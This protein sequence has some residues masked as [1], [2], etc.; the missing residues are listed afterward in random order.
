MWVLS[1]FPKTT[2]VSFTISKLPQSED[3]D[4][5]VCLARFTLFHFCLKSVLYFTCSRPLNDALAASETF[6]LISPTCIYL[7][8]FSPQ[9]SQLQIQK[10][11]KKVLTSLKIAC[12]GMYVLIML[13][14]IHLNTSASGHLWCQE[15]NSGSHLWSQE[16]LLNKRSLISLQPGRGHWVALWGYPEQMDHN[17][18]KLSHMMRRTDPSSSWS[19]SSDKPMDLKQGDKESILKPSTVVTDKPKQ[20][21]TPVPVINSTS[22]TTSY[23]SEFMKQWNILVVHQS[24]CWAGG[25]VTWAR[26]VKNKAHGELPGTARNLLLTPPFSLCCSHTFWHKWK[27]LHLQESACFRGGHHGQ[28]ALCRYG[29]I[30]CD[31]A[32]V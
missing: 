5:K 6:S 28:E 18:V 24:R 16:I 3:T 29:F 20:T 9:G 4:K 25:S 32:A 26:T 8:R 1:R 14:M 31:S 22:N 17:C 13:H 12:T 2:N 30:T 7:T 27:L 21:T 11:K 10:R 19:L 15:T 23:K